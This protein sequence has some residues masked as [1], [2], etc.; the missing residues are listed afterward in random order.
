MVP[1]SA[2]LPLSHQEHKVR[3][4]TKR[5]WTGQNVDWAKYDWVSRDWVSRLPYSLTIS[6]YSASLIRPGGPGHLKHQ[7]HNGRGDWIAWCW[8]YNRVRLLNV[9]DS[10]SH[11]CWIN[12]TLQQNKEHA[13]D[14]FL[15]ALT[16]ADIAGE[17]YKLVKCPCGWQSKRSV[18]PVGIR[19]PCARARTP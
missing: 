12:I 16:R 5:R 18:P 10:I 1:A 11:R 8:L 19:I 15:V 13:K 7:G 3:E 17:L 4:V 2:S 14:V 6:P 9:V